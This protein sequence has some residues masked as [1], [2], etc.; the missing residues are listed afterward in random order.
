MAV[1]ILHIKVKFK[2]RH[3]FEQ[4]ISHF[5]K[6][7]FSSLS[8]IRIIF[9]L[10]SETKFSKTPRLFFHFTLS[11]HRTP[12]VINRSRHEFS[13]KFDSNIS[14]ALLAETFFLSVK[15][16]QPFFALADLNFYSISSF[17]RLTSMKRPKNRGRNRPFFHFFIKNHYIL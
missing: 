4:K 7:Q 13:Y 15:K 2:L 12:V 5:P 17:P 14:A 8:L 6:I 10:E 11:A 3:C 9:L 1:N 16:G